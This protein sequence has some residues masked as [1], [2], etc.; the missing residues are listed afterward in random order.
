MKDKKGKSFV[1][2]MMIIATSSL[3][4]TTAIEQL[5][6]FN[7]SQNEATALANLKLISAA[8]E[9]YAKNNL[10]AFPTKTS[11]LVEANPAYLKKDY[12]NP[13]FRNNGYVYNC[14]LLQPSGYSCSSWPIKCGLNGKKIF[15]VTTGGS[16]TC[17]ECI[18]KEK[19]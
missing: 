4:L 14:S 16:L 15:T 18:K 12:F 5:I 8:F 3:V 9:S 1:V 6:K 10:G 17:A 7:I 13:R 11:F 2:I 19:E